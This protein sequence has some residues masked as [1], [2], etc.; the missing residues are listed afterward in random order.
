MG[1]L[2]VFAQKISNGLYALL[3]HYFGP[4]VFSKISKEVDQ[5]SAVTKRDIDK[6]SFTYEVIVSP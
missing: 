1:Q 2:P 3:C 4:T 6:F 5:P